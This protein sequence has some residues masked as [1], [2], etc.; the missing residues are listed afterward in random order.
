V[1]PGIWAP[2]PKL[3]ALAANPNIRPFVD[4]DACVQYANYFDDWLT[5]RLAGEAQ[6]VVAD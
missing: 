6:P 1:L 2:R 4:S 3:Q 5:R